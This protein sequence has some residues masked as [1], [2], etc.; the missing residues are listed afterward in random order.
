MATPLSMFKAAERFIKASARMDP[1]AVDAKCESEANR[2]CNVLG[3]LDMDQDAATELLEALADEG[4]LFNKDQRTRISKVIQGIMSDEV[5]VA[6]TRA[7]PTVKE[8]SFLKSYNYYP[9]PLWAVLRSNDTI[10]NKFKHVSNFLVD[11]M[12]CRNPDQ[13]SK[14]IIVATVHVA[15]GLSPE[16][17][18]AFNDVKEFSNV[19]KLTR[20]TTRGPQSLKNF[21][22]DPADFQT[23]Y[24]TAY[25]EES[26]P[27]KCKVNPKE[28]LVRANKDVTPLRGNNQKLT[29]S[30]RP[31]Q[32][33]AIL[34]S[35]NVHPD[36]SVMNAMMSNPMMQVMARQMMQSFING[37]GASSYSQED[38]SLVTV[39]RGKRKRS[40]IQDSQRQRSVDS[41][42]DEEKP[43]V[44]RGEKPGYGTDDRVPGCLRVKKAAAQSNLATLQADVQEKLK[45]SAAAATSSGE[46]SN[47]EESTD[48]E[49]VRPPKKNRKTPTAPSPT[50]STVKKGVLK[51][52][53]AKRP[54]ASIH[55][56]NRTV[57]QVG[58][59]PTTKA[60]ILSNQS[61]FKFPRVVASLVAKKAPPRR[62]EPSKTITCYA[63]GKVYWSNTKS[64]F[65]VMKR[66][67]DAMDQRIGCDWNNKK[68][69]KKQWALACALIECDPRARE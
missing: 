7:K 43:A 9:E 44:A 12:Q 20:D 42:A 57:K 64:T 13:Q 46:E 38:E 33:T 1:S 67:G 58:D 62:P 65:R 23:R 45:R 24:P 28:I 26:P 56:A 60:V 63:G 51:K 2:L 49:D 30:M 34:P 37:H 25:P 15:S 10:K 21:P 68:D 40:G 36:M 54:A 19:M 50:S 39:L 29:A 27:V 4:S 52:P 18:E 16:P 59:N 6:S 41:D 53:A 48:G 47:D 31:Q 69:R 61:I 14:R 5:H 8:Q 11:V 3:K 32:S 55:D 35:Q 17:D 22:D 66:E